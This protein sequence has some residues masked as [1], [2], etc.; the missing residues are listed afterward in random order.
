MSDIA[1]VVS[2]RVAVAMIVSA[3]IM[4]S[5]NPSCLQTEEARCV[6]EPRSPFF[7]AT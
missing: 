6:P 1:N 7:A 5:M 3:K 2:V 4:Q